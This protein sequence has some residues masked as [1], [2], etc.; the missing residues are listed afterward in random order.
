LN[1]LRQ[2]PSLEWSFLSPS[3]DLAPGQRTGKFRLGKDQMLNDKNGQSRISTQDYAMAMI[4]EVERPAH[5]R[6]RFTA[7]Y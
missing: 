3:A 7:G 6:E 5:V 1:L 2:E 4:N